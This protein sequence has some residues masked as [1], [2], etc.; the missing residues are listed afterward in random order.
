MKKINIKKILMN[1]YSRMASNLK[2]MKLSIC[3]QAYQET[4]RRKI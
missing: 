3:G 4:N 1:R 2:I